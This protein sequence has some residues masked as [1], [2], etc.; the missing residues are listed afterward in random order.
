VSDYIGSPPAVKKIPVTR[1]C[2]FSFTIQR[3]N[4]Q[5]QPLN[6]ATGT[7][8]YLWVDIDKA[9][10]IKVNAVVSGSTAAVTI[11]DA[12]CDLVKNTTRWRA[13]IDQGDLEVPLLV[14]RFERNDG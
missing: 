14:G 5:G 3:V 8:V 4:T 10:P 13:V 6:F 1:G 2:D 7:T 11:S 9:N 12:V